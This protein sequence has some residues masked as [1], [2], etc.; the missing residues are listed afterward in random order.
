MYTVKRL[1]N[2][3]TINNEYLGSEACSR[4]E[5]GLYPPHGLKKNN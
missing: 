5:G 3:P 1:Y 2:R 4:G